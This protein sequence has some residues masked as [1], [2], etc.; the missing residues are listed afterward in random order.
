MARKPAS[1]GLCRDKGVASYAVGS[2]CRPRRLADAAGKKAGP[3]GPVV[4]DF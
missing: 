4:I 3:E 2:N 1:R